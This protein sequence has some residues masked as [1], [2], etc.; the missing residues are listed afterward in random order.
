[1]AEKPHDTLAAEEFA[2]PAPDPHSP[3]AV[4]PDPA[5]I[6]E[7]HDTLAAEAFAIPAPDAAPRRTAAQRRSG[8]LVI[9]P[10]ALVAWRLVRRLRG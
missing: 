10:V 5:G 6:P 4:P 8:A 3:A 7:P 9:V 1:M 2:I